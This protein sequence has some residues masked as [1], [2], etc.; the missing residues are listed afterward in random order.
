M[1]QTKPAASPRYFAL[2]GLRAAAM[3]LG[4]FYHAIQFGGMRGGF[5]PGGPG[6]GSMLAQEW[7]HSFRM[8]LF[9][10][11]SGFFSRLMLEKYGTQKFLMRR[12]RRLALPMVLGLFL[13]VPVYLAMRGGPGGPMGGG[14]PGGGGGPPNLSGMPSPPAGFVPPPLRRFDADGDGSLSEKEWEAA[15]A[16]LPSP[17]MGGPGPRGPGGPPGMGDTGRFPLDYLWFL[18]YLLVFTTATPLLLRPLGWIGPKTDPEDPGRPGGRLLAGVLAPLVLGL[19]SFPALMATPSMFGWGL[20]LASGIF[21]SFPAF[22]YH[23]EPDMPFYYLYFLCGWW[24][25]RRRDSLPAVARLWLPALVVGI[26]AHAV[27]V[28]LSARYAHQRGIAH[29]D[30]IRAATYA[31]YAIGSAFTSFGFLGLFQKYLDRPTRAGRYLADSAFWVYFVHLPLLV[32]MLDLLG[33]LGLPWWAQGGLVALAT[34][35][36][37]LVLYDWLVLPTPLARLFGP[38]TSN[39]PSGDAI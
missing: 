20:G 34:T 4:V 1:S 18:W 14:P 6:G 29:H 23:L 2:D 3:L 21:R 25:H 38:A 30:A 16:E 5:G 10:L 17:G 39:R 26:A 15:R 8:P 37:A 36:V 22:L 7:L 24:L 33:G 12:W 19:A 11:I 28:S 27:A 35:A 31:V 32:P 13:V 9:F